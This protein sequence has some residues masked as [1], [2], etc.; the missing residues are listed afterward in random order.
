[1]MFII[2]LVSTCDQRKKE[3]SF[4][5]AT[6]QDYDIA[7][8]CFLKVC[9]NKYM[10]PLTINQKRIMKC[11][12]ENLLLKGSVT[13]LH[14]TC[15]NFLTVPE[16]QTNLGILAKYGLLNTTSELQNYKELE[17]YALPKDFNPNEKLTIPNFEEIIKI[18]EKE[19]KGGTKAVKV[20]K[21]SKGV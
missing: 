5:I 11:F 1:M 9:S 10:I 20:E 16:L 13:Q 7:R 8:K 14:S 3:R 15:M 4:L 17:I 6:P 12:E 2:N 21:G 18:R 19:I